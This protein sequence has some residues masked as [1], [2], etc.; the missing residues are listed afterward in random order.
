MD[1]ER[2]K[3]LARSEMD[4]FGLDTWTL[5]INY[6]MSSTFGRCSS[7]K[8]IISLSA[9]LI[10]LNEEDRVLDTI[11]HEIAHALREQERGPI[12]RQLTAGEWHDSRWKHIAAEIGATPVQY[13]NSPGSKPVNT[14]RASGPRKKAWKMRCPNCG[15][16]GTTNRRSTKKACAN[17]YDETGEYFKWIYSPNN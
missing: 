5:D 8:K 16:T 3:T 17:C 11:L 6:V 9:I 13:Y 2:A 14:G 7:E 15:I 10:T 1:L 4:R 12:C